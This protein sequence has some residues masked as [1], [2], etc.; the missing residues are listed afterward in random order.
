MKAP[1]R[2]ETLFSIWQ[3][4]LTFGLEK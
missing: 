3:K 1:L 4:H 2:F